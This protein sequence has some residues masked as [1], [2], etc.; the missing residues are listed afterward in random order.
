MEL[1]KVLKNK[2]YG[3]LAFMFSTFI[4]LFLP[5]VQSLANNTDLWYSIILKQNHGLN[6]VLFLIFSAIFGIFV[7]FQIYKFRQPKVCSIRKSSTGVLG[8]V[9]AFFVGVCPACIGFAG[10]FFPATIITTLVIFGSIFMLISIFLI[11]LSIH[12]NGG[13][14]KPAK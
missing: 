13:F 14:K 3:L 9:F 12:L 1:I 8:S 4:F 2:N 7:S 5:F 11:L 6:L 10:L